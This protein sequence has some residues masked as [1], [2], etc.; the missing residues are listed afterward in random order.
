[1]QFLT[2]NT[3][4]YLRPKQ[5]Y[6]RL[7]AFIAKCQKVDYKKQYELGSR[8]YDLR[9]FWDEHGIIEY[10]HGLYRYPADNF[11]EVLDFAKEHNISI[12]FLFEERNYY[13]VKN[14]EDLREKF[15]DLCQK[16][17]SLYP[18]INFWGGQCTDS[19]VTLYKFKNSKSLNVVHRYSSVTSLFKSPKNWLA[20]LDDLCP[21]LYAKLMNKKNINMY[22][23]QDDVYLA[24]DFI[25][26]I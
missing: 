19:G 7:F 21:W 17:E 6:C 5:W 18:T 2:H 20:Q 10:R 1:M 14:I 25:N 15:K 12:R 26:K 22:K 8:C 11:Y 23:D 3:M 9:I 24:I 13:T 4:T 16:V